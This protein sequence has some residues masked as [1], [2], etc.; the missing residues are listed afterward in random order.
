MKQFL[1]PLTLP[2]S[3]NWAV[4]ILRVGLSLL[5]VGHGYEKFQTLVG[6]SKI[7]FPDPLG[8]SPVFSLFLTVFAEF[9]CSI[10]LILGLLTRLA[11][12]PLIICMLVIVTILNPNA[13]LSDLEHGLMYLI[14][15]VALLLTGPGK[16][17]ADATLFNSKP[18]KRA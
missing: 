10:L 2:A 12:I 15:Y 4:F 17:S 14:S 8:T 18:H 5:M 9:F 7:D 3:A 1:K 11:L 16:Y 13:P 6:G